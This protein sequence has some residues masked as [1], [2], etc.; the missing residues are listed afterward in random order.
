MAAADFPVCLAKDGQTGRFELIALLSLMEP[1]NLFWSAGQWRSTYLPLAAALAPFT[2]SSESPLGL[3]IDEDSDRFRQGS[4]LFDQHDQPSEV[5]SAIRANVELLDKDLADAR[6][7][8]DEFARLGLIRPIS[9][10]ARARS[11]SDHSVEGLYSLDPAALAA[12]ADDRIV[13]LYRAGH[14]A[15]A[16]LM[17]ASLNQLERLRQSHNASSAHVFDALSAALD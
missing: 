14:V 8:I 15:A 3:A 1:R 9:L 17:C 4:P 7:M 13:A 6:R 12:L 5:L 11:G 10:V 16:S 2:S